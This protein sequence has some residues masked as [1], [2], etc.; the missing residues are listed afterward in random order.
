MPNRP[1]KFLGPVAD[2]R[3]TEL[4]EVSQIFANL[5]IGK[6]KAFAQLSRTYCLFAFHEKLLQFAQVKTETA[7]DRFRNR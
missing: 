3:I 2:S 5:R 4:P 7:D 1:D 6:P